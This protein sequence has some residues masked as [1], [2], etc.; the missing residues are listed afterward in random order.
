MPSS[1][2][3]DFLPKIIAFHSLIDTIGANKV[4]QTPPPQSFGSETETHR[5]ANSA[6]TELG[7]FVS[8]EE[9]PLRRG[10]LNAKEGLIIYL[11]TNNTHL[12]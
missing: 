1:A 9:N 5:R 7:R 8:Q 12:L 3:F 10:Y 2:A 11:L 4:C 6:L